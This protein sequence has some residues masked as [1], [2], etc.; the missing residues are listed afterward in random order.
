MAKPSALF[1]F[2]Y[3]NVLPDAFAN[4]GWDVACCDLLPGEH[5]H[6][7]YQCDWRECPVSGISLAVCSP[8]CTYLSKAG[9]NLWASR[10]SQVSRAFQDVLN[11]WALPVPHLS[12]ENPVG[13]LNTNWCPPSQIVQPYEFGDPYWKQTCFWLRGLPPL[14]S[15]RSIQPK[16]RWLDKFRHGRPSA[17]HRSRFFPGIAQAMAEQWTPEYLGIK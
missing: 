11:V 12:L 14:I 7:H 13:W 3:S 6:L 5:D 10:T 2:N 15:T 8:P 9:A 1:L 4:A 16:Q 17:R